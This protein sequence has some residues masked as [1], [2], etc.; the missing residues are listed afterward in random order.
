M[1]KGAGPCSNATHACG[2]SL[3]LSTVFP[4][5][6]VSPMGHTGYTLDT[7]ITSFDN[8]KW[9]KKWDEANVFR[10]EICPP[11]YRVH[12]WVDDTWLLTTY[13]YDMSPKPGQ[14]DHFKPFVHQ[15]GVY[16]HQ[17]EAFMKGRQYWS[18][19]V[20]E[21]WDP[22]NNALSTLTLG[23]MSV[24]PSYNRSDMLMYQETRDLGDGVF[25]VIYMAYN[26]NTSYTRRKSKN[27]YLTDFG[28]WGGVRTSKLPDYIVSKPDHSW[29]VR[30]SGFPTRVF[31]ENSGGWA[32]ATANAKEGKSYALGY[33]FGT[34][35]PPGTGRGSKTHGWG[36]THRAR[37][38][39]VQAH[40]YRI[41]LRPGTTFY[42][43]FFLV[44]G[45]LNAVIEKCKALAPRSDAGFLDFPEAKATRIPLYLEERD[46]QTVI[47][48]KGS[49]PAFHVYAEP[50]NNSKPLYLIRNN[51]KNQLHATCDPYMVMPRY[52]IPTDP[53][54]KGLRP[55]DGST[56]IIKVYGYVMPKEHAD[57][58]LGHVPLN[59]ILTDKSFYPEDGI[60]DASVVVLA[61][62]R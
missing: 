54:K 11:Q 10:F 1:D 40:R 16:I 29:E 32:I 35:R 49:T 13:Q 39:T 14:T 31:A 5:D 58:T 37:D 12:A 41:P 56:D 44:L 30:N 61:G 21:D 20:A 57:K 19:I 18:P 50:V 59:T 17:D 4:P 15:A 36:R 23:M 3:L 48:E 8:S 46:G 60:Y 53:T 26:Y 7:G 6:T 28:P 55:Y 43:R 27:N 2:R 52:P 9:Y 33:V 45:R 47:A 34:S 38:Y 25:E 62:S 51:R 22:E 42:C 24:G